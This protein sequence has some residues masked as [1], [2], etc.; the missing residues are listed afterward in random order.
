[1]RK[2]FHNGRR[3]NRIISHAL[4]RTS[5][6][7]TF[8]KLPFQPPSKK[9]PVSGESYSGTNTLVMSI[10]PPNG[11][12]ARQ[13]FNSL[14]NSAG[15]YR[16]L[17]NMDRRQLGAR[18]NTLIPRNLN[19]L[20]GTL[21]GAGQD[22]VINGP[23][24]AQTGGSFSAEDQTVPSTRLGFQ[25]NRRDVLTTNFP[26]YSAVLPNDNNTQSQIA[27]VADY[28]SIY[29]GL[30]ATLSGNSNLLDN[31]A[32]LLGGGFTNQNGRFVTGGNVGGL[33]QARASAFGNAISNFGNNSNSSFGARRVNSRASSSGTGGTS[34]VTLNYNK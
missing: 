20:N 9:S 12:P 23:I 22:G 17:L 34:N 4:Q 31:S 6:N 15:N 11:T 13:T 25:L 7:Y 3:E 26:G 16:I 32:S 24:D 33:K 19:V 18:D 2:I 30:S 21:V 1:M 8:R 28:L 5:V 10:N 27:D 29:S 14:N